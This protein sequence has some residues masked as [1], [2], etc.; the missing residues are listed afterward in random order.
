MKNQLHA[1][2]NNRF[3]YIKSHPALITSTL[4]DPRFKVKYLAG[5]EVDIG[6]KEIVHGKTK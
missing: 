5:D 6:I 1:C 2:L 3:A 4:L